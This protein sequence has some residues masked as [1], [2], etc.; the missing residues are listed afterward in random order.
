[1]RIW[2]VKRGIWTGY[3]V[4]YDPKVVAFGLYL[5]RARQGGSC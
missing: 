5:E 2:L 1:M 3:G 4:M